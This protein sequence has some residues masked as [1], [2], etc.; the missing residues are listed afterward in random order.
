MTTCKYPHGNQEHRRRKKLPGASCFAFP[1]LLCRDI[2]V[3]AVDHLLQLVVLLQ[4]DGRPLMLWRPGEEDVE[5]ET[6]LTVN[7][8]VIISSFDFLMFSWLFNAS[9]FRI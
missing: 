1:L 3:D 7:H 5:Q 4:A 2:V 9:F 6:E 8:L